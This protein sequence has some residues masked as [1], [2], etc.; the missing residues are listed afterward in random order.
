MAIQKKTTSRTAAA[1]KTAPKKA[2]KKAAP[3]KS[4]TAKKAPAKKTTKKKAA[5][6]KAAATMPQRSAAVKKGGARPEAK[7][8]KHGGKVVVPAGVGV[9]AAWCAIF[10][11]NEKLAKKS[12]LTDEGITKVLGQAFPGR[13]SDVFSRVQG[14]RRKYNTGGFTQTDGVPSTL[15]NRYDEEGNVTTARGKKVVDKKA[16][17]GTK[18]TGTKKAAPKRK[19]PKRKTKK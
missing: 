3:K 19:A 11:A 13:K 5:A 7:A 16:A 14:V 1:K 15:S 2:A 4:A 17:S 9:Q 18:K 8:V 12:K 10:E 6:K